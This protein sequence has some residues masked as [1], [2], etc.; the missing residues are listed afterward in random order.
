MFYFVTFGLQKSFGI[1]PVEQRRRAIAREVARLR[2]PAS[3]A[4][5]NSADALLVGELDYVADSLFALPAAARFLA[6]NRFMVAASA[7]AAFA[8]GRSGERAGEGHVILATNCHETNA[9][10]YVMSAI[11]RRTCYLR[12]EP[13]AGRMLS[14]ERR[15]WNR[16]RGDW[17]CWLPRPRPPL[18]PIGT[19]WSAPASTRSWPATSWP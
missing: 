1:E 18:K 19:E 3:A 2:A 12:P 7:P 13:P 6:A 16:W 8:Y 17:D 5:A 10:I 4:N 11:D 15:G 9:W 14:P